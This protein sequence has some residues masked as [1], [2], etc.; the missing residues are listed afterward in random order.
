[1]AVR[2]RINRNVRDERFEMLRRIVRLSAGVAVLGLL[3]VGLVLYWVR[4]PFIQSITASFSLVPEMQVDD[5]PVKKPEPKRTSEVSGGAAQVTEIAVHTA[6]VS[7]AALTA[8]VLAQ[9][10]FSSDFSNVEGDSF[11][12]GVGV[13]MGD[14]F[15]H[16][17]QGGQGTGAGKGKGN[18]SGHA[19]NQRNKGYNDDIQVVFVLD[20][21]GSMDPLFAAVVNSMDRMLSTLSEGTLNGGK[22]KVNVGVVVYGQRM[23]DGAPFVLSNFTTN[24]GDLKSKLSKQDCTGSNEECGRAIDFALD[25]FP[26]NQRERDDLLKVIFI[27]G[28]ESFQQ[29]GVDY[30]KAIQKAKSKHVIVNT[31]YCRRSGLSDKPTSDQ[32]EWAAA[33]ELAGGKSLVFVPPQIPKGEKYVE[34]MAGDEE[35]QGIINKVLEGLQKI[36]PMAS[37][38]P[39]EQMMLLKSATVPPVPKGKKASQE[40]YKKYRRI[41]LKGYSWDV[42]EQCRRLGDDGM[43]LARLGGRGNLPIALRGMSDEEA[44]EAI[45]RAAHERTALLKEYEEAQGDVNFASLLLEVLQDQAEVRSILLEI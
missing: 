1:M 8:D 45:R 28:D 27:C 41:L 22:V 38:S 11:S 23:N 39:A 18:G 24:I 29:G 6:T 5:T 20:A 32:K 19:G 40:W 7:S 35:R 34:T 12:L 42:V 4:L 13:D 2:F 10:D 25:N 37:G 16:V 26:W 36:Q 17:G 3:V 21:S 14:A 43:T 33:A 15:S 44:L 9:S 31:V 30:I